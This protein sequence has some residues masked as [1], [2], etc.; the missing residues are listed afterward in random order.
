[1]SRYL[2]ELINKMIEPI[3]VTEIDLIDE[4]KAY[5][6]VSFIRFAGDGQALVL[7]DCGSS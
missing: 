1:M 6:A 2:P 4:L 3:P 7:C 5:K